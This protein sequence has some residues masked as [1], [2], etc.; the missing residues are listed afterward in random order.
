[1]PSWKE[2]LALSG[3]L[4][5]ALVYAGVGLLPGAVSAV[6]KGDVAPP[7][8]LPNLTGDTVVVTGAGTPGPVAL[9]FWATWCTT[10][11][12][13]VPRLADDIRAARKA[14]LTVHVVAVESEIADVRTFLEKKDLV[15]PVLLDTEGEVTEQVFSVK[16]VPTL[17]LI[18]R[19]GIIVRHEKLNPRRF[20][21]Q[22]ARLA[23]QVEPVATT[24]G[25][26]PQ[27]R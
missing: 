14:G 13:E 11:R 4:L 20:G 15:L 26:P 5:V 6:S 19:D 3:V 1:V 16:Y 2:R 23:R 22:L 25:D 24:D 12:H 18:D 8:Q 27:G 7:L 21:S 17:V 9:V 10:C